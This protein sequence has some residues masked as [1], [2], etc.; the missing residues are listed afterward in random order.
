M[1]KTQLIYRQPIYKA[2]LLAK[3]EKELDRKKFAVIIITSTIEIGVFLDN[4]TDSGSENLPSK[5][6]EN[7]LEFIQVLLTGMD[8]ELI[9]TKECM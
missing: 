1:T 7:L 2:S 9:D 4:L 3:K 5:D 8:H 6:R